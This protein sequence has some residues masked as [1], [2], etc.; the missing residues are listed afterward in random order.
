MYYSALITSEVFGPSNTS[1]IVDLLGNDGNIYTPQYAVYEGDVLAKVGGV[2]LF[3]FDF[4][5]VVCF[6]ISSSP[7][8]F[9]SCQYFVYRIILTLYELIVW[10]GTKLTS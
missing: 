4:G 10:A 6:D 3:Q 5:G 9:S 8:S 1:R 2:F 7:F